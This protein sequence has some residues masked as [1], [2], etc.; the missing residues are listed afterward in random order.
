M[1]AIQAH[2]TGGP[3]VL[4]EEEVP[5]PQPGP[6][7][8]RVRIAAAGV[9]F[10]DTYHRTGAYPL[11][12]P[13]ALGVEAAG[14]VDA[15]GGDVELR[16]G[17]RVAYALER[18]SYAEHA[19]VPADRL[20]PVPGGI[21]LEQAAAVMLQGMTAHYLSHSTWPLASGDTALVLAAAGGVGHLLV[22]LAK[23]RGARVLATTSTEEKADLARRAGADEV[24][25]YTRTAIDQEVRRL[26]G[27]AGVDVAYDS[28][29]KTTFDQSLASLRPRGMLVLYG[30]S[31]GPVGPLDPQVLNQQGSLFLTRP[32]LV[33]Y[34]ADRGELLQ[35]AED[36]FGWMAAGELEVR[37]DRTWPLAEAAEA[38]QYLEA[39]ETKGKLLLVP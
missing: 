31:S 39:G 15:V 14:V 22:Q 1:R 4:R 10:I 32:S 11:D 2:Q 5:T 25:L 9:N 36:L 8:A 16:A 34:A 6:G 26:T 21:E 13:F 20:V 18:G 35:R 38:H 19:V 12:I 24:I 27:G 17:D 37:V 33:H 29:G 30:Q 3:E 7:E 23:R 28:V